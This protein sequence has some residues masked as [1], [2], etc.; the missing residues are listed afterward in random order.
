MIRSWDLACLAAAYKSGETTPTAVLGEV[1]RRI[2][3]HGERPT[4]ISLVPEQDA[5]RQAANLEARRAAGETLPLYGAPF[6][7]KDNIDKAGVPTTAAC[8]AFGYAPD[9]SATV[10]DRLEAAGAI[11]VGK[12]NL[13]QFATG[14]VGTRSPYG[15]CNS[16]FD[17]RYVS[18]GS[19]A[20]SA[21]AVAAGLVS[22]ALGTDTAGSGRVPA[23]FNNIVGLKPT[24]G[25]ISAAGVVPAVR[26]QDCVSVFAGCVGDA[27][28]ILQTA[29]GHDAADPFSR[30]APESALLPQAMPQPFRFGVP[31]TAL[32]FFGDQDA[33]QLYW[34]AVARMEALGGIRVEIDFV[35]FRDAARLLYAGPWV[36]ERLA[37][38]AEFADMHAADMH[39][40]VRDIILGAKHLSAVDAYRGMYA[41]AEFLQATET[42]WRAMDVFLLPTTGTIYPIEDVLRDPVALNSNLGYYTNF[43][44]LM[45][46]SAVAV[47]AGFRRADGP[48]A[49]L[50]FD[51]TVMGRAWQDGRIA[52]LAD[53]LHRSLSNATMGA[54]GVALPAASALHVAAVPGKVAVAV[55][56]AHLSGQP[57]NHQLTER[58]GRLLG[59]TRTASGYSLYALANNRPPKPGLILDG[60]GAGGIEVE[61]WELDMRDFGSFTA[62][63]PAPLSMGTVILADGSRVKG[64]L[65]EPHAI[66]DAEDITGFGGWR[67]WLARKR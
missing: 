49:G 29:A 25:A 42:A 51:V 21:V 41:L 56:G 36:A 37:A 33:E 5:L 28:R 59:T 53:R 47:P 18:G 52:T 22:F 16:V 1:Y 45:D 63:I 34:E 19:S 32:E 11:L 43:A 55:V 48:L 67:D 40:V 14:L 27:L 50:P 20:G 23:A 2:A 65:C 8:P 58:H 61:V 13:D 64:F 35:P 46:L 7:V 15:I 31:G 38:I 4:F 44:N 57:L 17:R 39:P 62:A 54:T 26:S 9:S 30:Q 60:R 10:V 3:Q 24:K 66:A 12:T 6:A